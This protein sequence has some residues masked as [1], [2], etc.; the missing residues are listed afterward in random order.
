MTDAPDG[1]KKLAMLSATTFNG[2]L[3]AGMGLMYFFRKN[4]VYGTVY[5]A[6]GAI[7]ALGA[8]AT[9]NVEPAWRAEWRHGWQHH[10]WVL[11][12]PLF[13]CPLA[14][15]L[16]LYPRAPWADFERYLTVSL[17]FFLALFTPIW[18]FRIRYHR[19]AE[20]T[21]KGERPHAF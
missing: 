16:A 6:M 12:L 4:P 9:K 8:F 7:P 17:L 2:V 1:K 14:V 11:A 19:D 13:I 5:C 15:L 3:F 21:A 18:M 10:R 20:L